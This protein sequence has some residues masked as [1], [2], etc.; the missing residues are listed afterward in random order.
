[1]KLEWKTRLSK[2]KQPGIYFNFLFEC[3]RDGSVIQGSVTGNTS[4]AVCRANAPSHFE[5]PP[6]WIAHW[7]FTTSFSPGCRQV[8]RL[9]WNGTKVMDCPKKGENRDKA[10]AGEEKLHRAIQSRVEVKNKDSKDWRFRN[11]SNFSYRSFIWCVMSLHC[12]RTV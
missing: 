5:T 7:Y 11:L 12:C 9:Q 6:W 4:I 3:A 1:M 8:L 10:H 2:I